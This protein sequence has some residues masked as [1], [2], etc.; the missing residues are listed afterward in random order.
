MLH[1]HLI[2]KAQHCMPS[3]GTRVEPITQ[4]K[5]RSWSPHTRSC[6][7]AAL[8]V[9]AFPCPFRICRPH[10]TAKALCNR[11]FCNR[12]LTWLQSQALGFTLS[13]HAWSSTGQLPTCTPS[14]ALR[15]LFSQHTKASFKVVA[16]AEKAVMVMQWMGGSARTSIS[17][18][19]PYPQIAPDPN[20]SLTA[21]VP[22]LDHHY[23]GKSFRALP[24]CPVKA[25]GLQQHLLKPG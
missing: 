9:A 8:N 13:H 2:T 18:V 21:L 3:D 14:P 20:P 17:L 12:C 15:L 10:V 19:S 11:A 7:S 23:C 5:G 16:Q 24:T 6:W 4:G 25:G 22:L 1:F